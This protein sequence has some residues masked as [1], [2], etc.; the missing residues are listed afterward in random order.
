MYEIKGK[1]ALV[2]GGTRGIGLAL[3]RSLLEAGA[4]VVVNGRSPTD[5]ADAL[6]REYGAGRV[7]LEFGDVADPAAATELV[8]KTEGHFGRF[9]ILVHSAGGP[10]PGKITDLTPQSWMEAFDVH[11]HPVFHMFR[12]AHPYLKREGGAVLLVSSVAGIRGCPGTVA[13]QT[14]KGALIPL[15]RA[16]AFDH[17]PEDIRINVLAPGI[18]R[19]RFHET[20]TP[21]AKAHNIGNRIPLRRE[22]SVEDVASAAMELIRNE[23]VTGEIF[24]I[25]G[26]MSMRVTG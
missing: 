8:A 12:A 1:T 22:G 26:G 18:I 2:T 25:D 19:T 7:K 4:N 14:V 9:D 6:A 17:G 16:L 23:F 21:E 10:A 13:Y 11:V 3:A 20:M 24:T 15:A 5:E